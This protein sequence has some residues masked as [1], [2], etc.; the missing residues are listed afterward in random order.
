[1][2]APRTTARDEDRAPRALVAS[3]YFAGR[4]LL[5]AAVLALALAVLFLS[6]LGIDLAVAGWFHDGGRFFWRSG[7]TELLRDL[8]RL[9]PTLA[10]IGCALVLLAAIVGRASRARG[11]AAA[12]LLTVLALGPGLIVNGILKQFWGRPR[13]GQITEFGG[14][15]PFQPPFI[16]TDF[17]PSNCSFVSGEA[18]AAGWLMA[19]AIVLPRWR[20]PLFWGGLA[21]ALGVGVLRMGFGGHFLSDVLYGIAVSYFLAAALAPFFARVR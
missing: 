7:A 11:A 15:L 3:P 14:A 21:F 4:G 16:P 20:H 1:M 17:C 9:V 12:F 19:L 13:P 6:C 2:Q 5:A 10:A 8:G 18:S